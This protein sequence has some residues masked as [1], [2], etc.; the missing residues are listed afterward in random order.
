[1][2]ILESRSEIYQK[3]LEF[4]AGAQSSLAVYDPNMDCFPYH[5]KAF[6]DRLDDFLSGNGR[7]V[8][9]FDRPLNFDLLPLFKS[10]CQRKPNL[11]L[12]LNK[13]IGHNAQEAYAVF[14]G[15]CLIR[16]PQIGMQR[17]AVREADSASCAPYL[18]KIS[19]MLADSEPFSTYVTGL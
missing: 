12:R 2:S 3:T 16:Y 19:E 13:S 8:I 1:M 11:E 14:D 4:S 9:L 15:V 5:D 6:C 10:I 17:A 7:A 18:N